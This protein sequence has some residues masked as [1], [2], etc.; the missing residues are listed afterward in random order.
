MI[1]AKFTNSYISAHTF[2]LEN[3]LQQS[4]YSLLEKSIRK[5]VY[6]AVYI[7]STNTNLSRSDSKEM[8]NSEEISNF[9]SYSE[10]ISD[11]GSPLAQMRR[12]VTFTPVTVFENQWTRKYKI[13]GLFPSSSDDCW[14]NPRR[15]IR[16]E[17]FC[18]KWTIGKIHIWVLS[19]VDE[20]S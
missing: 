11:S 7:T 18:L 13:T 16:L 9:R 10:E 19:Q 4:N 14:D 17:L 6:K 1:A 5:Y 8:R 20:S 12:H 2:K 3:L 15:Q